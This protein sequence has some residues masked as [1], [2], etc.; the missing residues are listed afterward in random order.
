MIGADGAYSA[1][2]R[3]IQFTDGFDFSQDFLPHGYKELTIPARDGEFALDPQIAAHLAA[4][5]RP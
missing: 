1:V 3:A 5:R 4:R 2:R